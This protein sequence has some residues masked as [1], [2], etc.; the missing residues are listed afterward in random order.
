MS[1]EGHPINDITE[2]PRSRGAV[3]GARGLARAAASCGASRGSAPVV[4]CATPASALVQTPAASPA[5]GNVDV[6]RDDCAATTRGTLFARD[7]SLF[8]RVSR[9]G[10]ADAPDDDAERRA[11]DSWRFG[12]TRLAPRGDRVVTRDGVAGGYFSTVLP[13]ADGASTGVAVRSLSADGSWG[14]APADELVTLSV[15][16]LTPRRLYAPGGRLRLL[17]RLDAR[18]LLLVQEG[19][20]WKIVAVDSRGSVVA[21]SRVIGLSD[22]VTLSRAAEVGLPWAAPAGPRRM[23]LAC[24]SDHICAVEVEGETITA[25]DTGMGVGA[26]LS[27]ANGEVWVERAH[28]RC[29]A[30]RGGEVPSGRAVRE[31]PC[32]QDRLVGPEDALPVNGVVNVNYSCR[33][34]T[35]ISAGRDGG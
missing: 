10:G 28:Q 27:I 30:L 23:F 7:G 1:I 11:A 18:I 32:P 4:R 34:T 9:D 6:D 24:E 16:T 31:V 22:A 33:S 5:S 3:L 17:G 13:I 25:R 20:A 8:F 14:D 29:V 19:N 35:T 12:V 15:D 21:R 2:G 26:G